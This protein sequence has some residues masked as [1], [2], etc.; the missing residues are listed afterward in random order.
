M[1]QEILPLKIHSSKINQPLKV[2]KEISDT[3]DVTAR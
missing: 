2:L 1:L 3:L